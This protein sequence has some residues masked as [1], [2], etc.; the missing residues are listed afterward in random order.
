MIYGVEDF[1]KV[2]KTLIDSTDYLITIHNVLTWSTYDMWALNPASPFLNHDQGAL[3]ASLPGHLILKWNAPRVGYMKKGF[4][5][6]GLLLKV[7]S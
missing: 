4:I 5:F 2:Y 3:F 1:H 7:G 6:S